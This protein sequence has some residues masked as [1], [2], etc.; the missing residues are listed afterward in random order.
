MHEV[1]EGRP[2]LSPRY[3]WVPRRRNVRIR[4]RC[5]SP[6]F[7][8][9]KVRVPTCGSGLGIED[10]IGKRGDAVLSLAK[11]YGAS[12][13]RVFGSVARREATKDSDVDIPVD[14]VR[15]GK[16]RLVP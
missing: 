13:V 1:E 6:C 3:V 11:R 4:A 16:Y 10:V 2:L 5:K 9:P 8:V 12:N 7:N 14:P 15:H